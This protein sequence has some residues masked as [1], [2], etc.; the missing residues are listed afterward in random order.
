MTTTTSETQSTEVLNLEATLQTLCEQHGLPA[1]GN[2][3]VERYGRT[4]AIAACLH[5]S[6]AATS[7]TS[8]DPSAQTTSASTILAAPPTSWSA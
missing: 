8:S 1:V 7:S 6:Q 4:K 2:A 3:L 5:P